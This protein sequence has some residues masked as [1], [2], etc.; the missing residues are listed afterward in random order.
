MDER[1]VV[2]C[3]YVRVSTA[4]QAVSGLGIDAQR[5]ALAVAARSRG[6]DIEAGVYADEGISGAEMGKRPAL[7]EAL[8]EI[9]EGRAGGLV[10][11]KLDRLARNTREVLAIADEAQRDGWRLVILDLDV[12]TA[13]PMGRMVLTVLAAVG[14]LERGM[15]AERQLAKHNALR[16]AGRPRGRKAVD[17]EVADR[18]RSERAMGATFQ[19]IADRLNAGG[20]PTARG[21]T[22]WRAPQVRSAAVTRDRELEAQASA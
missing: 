6:L 16:R 12:D 3:G 9:R 1:P 14:E 4:G 13:T 22:E 15:I 7:R 19:S 5:H 2:L 10:V 8:T 21:A 18:I 20:V 11:A 17:R